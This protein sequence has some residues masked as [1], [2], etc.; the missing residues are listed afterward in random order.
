[1][2]ETITIQV[3]QC[4]NQIGN[5]FWELLLA[6]HE[7]TPDDDDTLS[8]FFR[9]S[10]SSSS[11][12][13]NMK[14][15]ALLIDMECGPLQETMRSPLGVLFDNTQ[16]VMDVYGAGN[17]FAHG[18]YHY[19]PQ[20][21]DKFE[22]GI[23]KNVEECD[24]LSNFFV[25]HSLGGGTGSGVGSYI[26]SLLH[27][28]YPEIYRYSACV[29]PSEDN[30][31]VTSPYN[32]VLSID[33]LVQHADCVFP[34]DNA[35]LQKFNAL[36]EVQREKA[37]I[38]GG[39]G[40]SIDGKSGHRDK[41]SATSAG[42]DLSKKGFDE[43][44]SIAARMLCHLTSGSRF[45][46]QLN[47]DMNDINNNLVPYPRLKFLMTALSPRRADN[48]NVNNNNNNNRT[49][50]MKTGTN[51]AL[52]ALSN[53]ATI[54]RAFADVLSKNGQITS[55]DPSTKGSITIASAFFGRGQ[56]NFTDYLSSVTHAQQKILEYPFWNEGA[57]RIGL[58]DTPAPGEHMSLLAIYNS[59]ALS[60]V[61]GREQSRFN[62][63][64]SRK[65]MLHHY[66]E[67]V[68]AEAIAEAETSILDVLGDY[69]TIKNGAKEENGDIVCER[70]NP[71]YG[72]EIDFEKT[73][74]Y[75]WERF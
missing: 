67:F 68:D 40:R 69:E 64:H 42:A 33:Q 53:K 39:S 6:E 19:G 56:I 37:R 38:K 71:N 5:K 41:V 43:M 25:T 21:R 50:S 48:F 20:Y 58:C 59:T 17:N 54:Q 61:F 45:N 47:V 14:A 49:S 52:S 4:G 51:N 60:S 66:T 55:A 62:Q 2:R 75:Y 26:V 28:L 74:K 22:E 24:S 27:D 30:D 34:I 8:A 44:N 12:H 13:L 70:F 73:K 10:K 23:R 3:G 15:R 9:F 7:R 46:G 29:L 35:A 72:T 63:L 32:S 16:F 65:A 1:M 36:E 31:V 18:H 11:E 57:C